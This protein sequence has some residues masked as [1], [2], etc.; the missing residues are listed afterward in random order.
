MVNKIMQKLTKKRIAIVGTHHSGKT[1]LCYKVVA[2]LKAKGI[3][4]GLSTEPSRTSLYIASNIRTY[5][6]QLEIFAGTIK[7][8][9]EQERVSDIV[10]CDRSVIDVLAY[11]DC[12]N[13]QINDTNRGYIDAMKGFVDTY[14]LTY[15]MLFKISWSFNMGCTYD[16]IRIGDNAFQRQIRDRIDHHISRLDIP[17]IELKDI[18]TAEAE[19]VS[20]IVGNYLGER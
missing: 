7:N 5:E 9:I 17:Y 15:A 11:T 3:M 6:T 18:E 1:T 16:P 10:V 13:E 12:L 20:W 2:N 4:A 19:I 8:E 14:S